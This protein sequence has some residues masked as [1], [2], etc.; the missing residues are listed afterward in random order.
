MT[1]DPTL[2][3]MAQDMM[4]LAPKDLYKMHEKFEAFL[5]RWAGVENV[6]IEDVYT[7]VNGIAVDPRKI[8]FLEKITAIFNKKCYAQPFCYGYL[9]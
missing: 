9:G 7:Y 2:L 1:L 5:F 6:R 4:T 8:A 3:A